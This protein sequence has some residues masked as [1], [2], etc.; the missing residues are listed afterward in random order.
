MR[1]IDD[2]IIIKNALLHSFHI[3]LHVVNY[4]FMGNSIEIDLREI[5][6]QRERETE[7]KLI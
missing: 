2:T 1:K 5:D 6:K 4:P 3:L 7:F